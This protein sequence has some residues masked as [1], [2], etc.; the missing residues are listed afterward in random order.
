[1]FWIISGLGSVHDLFSYDLIRYKSVGMT[2]LI[3]LMGKTR[4]RDSCPTTHK[5]VGQG[6]HVACSSR[7][8]IN[9]LRQM[10]SGHRIQILV[11]YSPSILLMCVQ[12]YT[13]PGASAFRALSWWTDSMVTS[14]QAWSLSGKN[15]G[16]LGNLGCTLDEMA[17]H[18]QSW[19]ALLQLDGLLWLEDVLWCTGNLLL[20]FECLCLHRCF[21]VW[22]FES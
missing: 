21:L 7:D 20:G 17:F 5:L 2:V 9:R 13:L 4:P 6:S 8:L 22:S 12:E 19:N 15:M 16:S 1:M 3:L 14:H 10:T 11:D 18:M